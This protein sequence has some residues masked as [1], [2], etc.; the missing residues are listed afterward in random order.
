MHLQSGQQKL[1]LQSLGIKP[2]PVNHKRS[3]SSREGPKESK[4][5]LQA[6]CRLRSPRR[7]GGW[8]G[9]GQPSPRPSSS[10][11]S[12]APRPG[13]QAP[14]RRA[15]ERRPGELGRPAVR[16]RSRRL[17]PSQGAIGFLPVRQ[18]AG[19]I[20]RFLTQARSEAQGELA[21]A[22]AE[23]PARAPRTRPD[24]AMWARGC[25]RPGPRPGL[26]T[27][28]RSAGTRRPAA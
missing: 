14:E 24:P 1:Y 13:A 5:Q 11:P 18:S 3:H 10:A 8:E 6:H 20:V 2:L 4:S 27:R 15:A 25:R 16:G 23:D 7:V 19:E 17:G 21:G 22:H 26:I 12:A 9:A 28:N